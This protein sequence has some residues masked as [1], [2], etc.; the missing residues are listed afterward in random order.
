MN[1][2][3]L[4]RGLKRPAEAEPL[5]REVLSVAR[6]VLG[7]A[8]QDTQ[9]VLRQLYDCLRELDRGP[10]ARAL[11]DDFLRTTEL[12]ADDPFVLGVKAVRDGV[13]K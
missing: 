13:E 12:A 2:G 8:G 7:D 11:L 10:D 5:L 3:V 1:L 6:R 9:K 4:L